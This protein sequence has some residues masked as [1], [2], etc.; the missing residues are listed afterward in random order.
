ME[1][2]F[3]VSLLS[4]IL[5]LPLNIYDYQHFPGR[6]SPIFF[7]KF[8]NVHSVCFNLKE[9]CMPFFLLITEKYSLHT[10]N[11]QFLS[12]FFS[13]FFSQPLLLSLNPI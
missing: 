2:N 3:V 8:S 12:L 9:F 13:L 4:V 1:G 7:Y 11:L 6:I 10:V 5:P